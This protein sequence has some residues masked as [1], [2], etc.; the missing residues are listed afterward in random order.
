MP[1]GGLGLDIGTGSLGTSSSYVVLRPAAVAELLRGADGP[2]YKYMFALGDRV[3]AKAQ[4]EVGVKTGNL[5]DHIIK[6][7]VAKADGISVEVGADTPYTI[8]HH[9]GSNAVDGK[10]M[11]FEINGATIFAT[12]RV[13]IPPNRFLIRALDA[14]RSLV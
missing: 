12:R 3:K 7:I 1:S 6:R 4:E 14:A 5:R 8:Y 9:E 11:V 13:A 2:V 10:L